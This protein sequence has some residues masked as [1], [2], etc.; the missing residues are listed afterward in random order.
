MSLNITD[1]LIPNIYQKLLDFLV[2]TNEYYLNHIEPRCSI[3][4]TTQQTKKN[5]F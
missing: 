2:Q 4:I 3:C 5:A 1:L